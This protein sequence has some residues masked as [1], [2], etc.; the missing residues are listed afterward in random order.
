[1]ADDSELIKIVKRLDAMRDDRS[2]NRQSRTFSMF[3]VPVCDVTYLQDEGIFVLV[4]LD[5]QER[6]RFDKIDL[7]AMEIYRCLYDFQESF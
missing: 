1:M 5:D 2:G 4:Q 7:A 3:G 6:Y